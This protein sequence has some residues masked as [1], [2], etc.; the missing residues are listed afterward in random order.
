[1]ERE[2]VFVEPGQPV[3]EFTTTADDWAIEDKQA[4]FGQLSWRRTLDMLKAWREKDTSLDF[5]RAQY[6]HEFDHWAIST[7]AEHRY[8]S[9]VSRWEE[10]LGSEAFSIPRISADLGQLNLDEDERDSY[11]R[12]I[13]EL[14][15]Q[16][17]KEDWDGE[18]AAALSKD[19]I[20]KACALV[21]LFPSYASGAD[22]SAS[23]HGEIDFD[24][25]MD[26]GAM[27]TISVGPEGDI[28]FAW[29][30]GESV[31]NGKEPWTGQLP[32]FVLCSFE[33]LN[34]VRDK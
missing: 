27:L 34:T 20:T 31:L 13:A 8:T 28:A 5:Q 18:G 2:F 25:H 17:G 4:S 3:S 29:L 21:D 30:H 24:W 9:I 12:Q 15:S 10:V 22:I 7:L 1:M 32:Q 11:K 16:A 6:M 19:T 33:R 23:P 14:L 26:N